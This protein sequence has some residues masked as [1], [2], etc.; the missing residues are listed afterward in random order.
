MEYICMCYIDSNVIRIRTHIGSELL[1]IDITFSYKQF[2]IRSFFWM[3]YSFGTRPLCSFFFWKFHLSPVLWF[4][5]DLVSVMCFPIICI[6]FI[7]AYFSFYIPL[8]LQCLAFFICYFF[9]KILKIFIVFVCWKNP[10][11]LTKSI[12]FW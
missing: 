8:S 6:Y 9:L 11:F 2:F 1:Y 3:E 10:R 7:T 5:N 12:L 4:V